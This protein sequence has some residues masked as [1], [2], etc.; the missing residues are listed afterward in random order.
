MIPFWKKKTLS[1]MTKQEWESLC[2]GCGLCCLNRFE[3][4]ETGGIITTSVSCR[5]LDLITC[6]CTVYG[7]RFTVNPDCVKLRA[8]NMKKLSW[9]P[10]TCAYKILFE[11][12]ELKWWHPLVSGNPDTV[13]TSGISVR[14]KAVSEAHIHP[15][16][17]PL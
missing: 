6:Q 14:D 7:K 5:Y 2:D 16:D 17:L 13:H 9:L 8:N 3:D 11:D 12:R 1:E 10:R 4:M 15:E